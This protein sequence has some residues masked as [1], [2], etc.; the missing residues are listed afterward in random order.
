M[1]SKDVH[2]LT[3]RTVCGKHDFVGVIKDLE[4]GKLSY[5]IW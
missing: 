2:V 3:P 1:I 4:V 5:I